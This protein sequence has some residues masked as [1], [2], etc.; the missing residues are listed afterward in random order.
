MALLGL[1]ALFGIAAAAVTTG[2]AGHQQKT[3]AGL[4]D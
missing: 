3:V 1:L 4:G 2:P